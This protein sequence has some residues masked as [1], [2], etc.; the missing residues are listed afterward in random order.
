MAF[1]D[2]LRALRE[3]ELLQMGGAH[4]LWKGCVDFRVDDIAAA[5]GVARGTCYLHFPSRRAFLEAIVAHLDGS[6]SARIARSTAKAESLD[7][8]FRQTVLGAVASQYRTL[9]LRTRNEP[10]VANSLAGKVWPC[11]LH[12]CPCPY[13]GEV[14]TLEVIARVARKLPGEPGDPAP[15]L[16]IAGLL[17]RGIP[18]LLAAPIPEGRARAGSSDIQRFVTHILDRV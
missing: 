18:G 14:R 8:A 11:C 9:T 7:A 16:L 10:P 1:K 17:V 3:D 2:R 5:C 4:L 15:P 12:R 13:G 6:L